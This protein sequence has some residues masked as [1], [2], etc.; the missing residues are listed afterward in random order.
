M[1]RRVHRA[2]SFSFDLLADWRLYADP[3]AEGS[4]WVYYG[5]ATLNGQTGALAWSRRGMP[6]LVIRV[7]DPIELQ[8]WERIDLNR[9]IESKTAPGWE[10]VPRWP[11]SRGEPWIQ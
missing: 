7:R 2:K 3:P 5:V 10:G 8:L 11:S 9:E 4:D 6:R 1:A